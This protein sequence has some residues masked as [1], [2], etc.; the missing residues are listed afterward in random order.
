MP[1]FN[2]SKDFK[3][4]K[5]VIE[6]F[7]SK[8]PNL[9][10]AMGDSTI[11]MGLSNDST[12][13]VIDSAAMQPVYVGDSAHKGGLNVSAEVKALSNKGMDKVNVNYRYNPETKKF[14]GYGSKFIGDAS[15]LTAGQAISPWNVNYFSNLYK[16]PL[17]YSNF[18]EL[19]KVDVGSDP[20]AEVM[21]LNSAAFAGFGAIGRAGAPSN[22]MH[23]DVNI[24]SGLMTSAIINITAS[25]ALDIIELERSRNSGNPFASQLIS[26]KQKYQLY[27]LN[28]L[29]DYLGYYGNAGTGTN[30][31]LSVNNVIAWSG[32]GSSLSTIAN[33]ASVTR[34]SDIY[35]LVSKVINSFLSTNHN[36]FNKVRIGVSEVAW[37]ILSSVSYSDTYEPKSVM[38]II[39]ENYRAGRGAYDRPVD[40]QFVV[41]PMLGAS[42]I[43]NSL[44]TDY[45][46]I[47]A[48][49]IETGASETNQDIVLFGAPLKDF[50]YPVIPGAYNT[51]YKMLKRIAGVFAPVSSAVVA[52]S[53][54]GV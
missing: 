46:V 35:K 52:Y 30:G 48:P 50:V 25:Y 12:Y 11:T 13:G 5:K 43:F 6:G 1:N 42:S 3:S 28:I 39:E 37:N 2:F 20:W 36:K 33:G 32:I 9:A 38:V 54:F 27:V 4:V 7:V 41:D 24:Q 8:S 47:T 16:Q 51:Q 23:M 15:P 22:E 49:E 34:G 53:G 14:D 26:E 10:K 17:L 19:V 40:V 18:K 45:M 29:E 31:L 44:S 21:T